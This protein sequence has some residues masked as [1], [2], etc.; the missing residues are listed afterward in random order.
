MSGRRDAAG[1]QCRG[2]ARRTRSKAGVAVRQVV[3]THGVAKVEPVRPGARREPVRPTDEK[4]NG[5][6]ARS[7]ARHRRSRA[8]ADGGG[9]TMAHGMVEV[10]SMRTEGTN[11]G[12]S[13]S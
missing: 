6:T 9:V 5:E 10:E 2:G 12:T 7:D 1:R 8:D 3:A 4:S 13:C 11:R